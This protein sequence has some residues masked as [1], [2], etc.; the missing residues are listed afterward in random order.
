M[1]ERKS[2]SQ[3]ELAL[4]GSAHGGSLW[5]VGRLLVLQSVGDA[6]LR[7]R[8]HGALLKSEISAGVVPVLATRAADLARSKASSA[9]H[10]ALEGLVAHI[11]SA[12]L[13]AGPQSLV[14]EL[15]GL[16]EESGVSLEALQRATFLSEALQLLATMGGDRDAAV[17]NG[18]C[19]AAVVVGDRAEGRASLHA[20]NQ[21]YDGGG[22]WDKFPLVHLARPTEGLAHVSAGTVGVLKGNLTLNEAGVTIGGHFLFSSSVNHSGRGFTAVEREVA[23]AARTVDE[24]VDLIRRAPIMGCFAFVITDRSGA[25]CVAEC[26]GEGVNIRGARDGRLGMS[27]LFQDQTAQSRDLLRRWGAHRNPLSREV[28]V[29]A[30]LHGAPKTANVEDLAA[31]LNDRWDMA[32]G[33]MR[34]PAHVIAHAATVTAAIADTGALTY[35]IGEATAPASAGRFI[36]LSVREAFSGGD[37]T[38]AGSFDS[39]T[40]DTQLDAFR[41]Y[42]S[43]RDAW[44]EGDVGAAIDL[45]GVAEA[46]DP[47][48]AAYPR[49]R[50]RVLLRHLR[51]AEAQETMGKAEGLRQGANERAELSLLQGYA[52]DLAGERQT[53]LRFY[54]AV[55]SAPH[56]RG[57]DFDWINPRLLTEASRRLSAPFAD[58][59]AKTLE[60]S[61][62]LT[63]GA[64]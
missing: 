36:G 43:A 10:A 52:A 7:G 1:A 48:E 22:L 53:A 21:D 47:D 8:Q 9:A 35:W 13:N 42:L 28:R 44:R 2:A 62:E 56:Q 38:L 5:R 3:L 37:I 27:N 16:A 50:A 49:V 20:K 14:E 39:R 46:M 18:A 55:V 45:L 17:A 30:L 4:V 60:I 24:A 34:G 54:K 6:R 32:S 58:A 25:A 15:S 40:S 31:I 64:E 29:E 19:T 41:L 57:A 61:F 23:L 11:Y 26:D 33:R 59:D 12:I 51:W 63:S